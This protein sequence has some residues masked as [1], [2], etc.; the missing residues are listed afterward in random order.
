MSQKPIL[1]GGGGFFVVVLVR[2]KNN[3]SQLITVMCYFCMHL[4]VTTNKQQV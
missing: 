4:A 1:L 3:E 2:Q